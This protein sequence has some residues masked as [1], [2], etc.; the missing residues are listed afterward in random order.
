M[1]RLAAN[2]ATKALPNSQSVYIRCPACRRSFRRFRSQASMF[3]SVPC[4]WKT[5]NWL[6]KSFYAAPD[7]NPLPL[8]PKSDPNERAEVSLSRQ[9]RGLG[10][11]ASASAPS[12]SKRRN[13]MRD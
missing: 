7:S 10:P 11:C 6:L 9:L 5:I 8:I 12:G 1:P 4:Y 3:C 2:A 13:V